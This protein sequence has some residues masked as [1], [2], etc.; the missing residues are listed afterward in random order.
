MQRRMLVIATPSLV[1]SLAVGCGSRPNMAEATITAD[2]ASDAPEPGRAT[3]SL[4]DAPASYAQALQRWKGP[5]DVNAFIGARFEY[6]LQR[7]MQLSETQRSRNGRMP[8]HEPSAFFAQPRGVCVDLSRFA[9]ETLRAVDPA[10]RP[11]YVMIE[12]NPVAIRGNTLRRHW[13]ASFQR[14]GQTWFFADSKRPGHI[15][16]PYADTQ[17]FMAEYA[18]YRGREIVAF[19]EMDGYERKLH[20][21]SARKEREEE[22]LQ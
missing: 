2:P 14:D 4:A 13:V 1:A 19:K 17:A 6:D 3:M 10:S 9:V 7:A 16:G 12:F 20:S 21:A 5:A 11:G 15:A 8:I 18:K 22:A